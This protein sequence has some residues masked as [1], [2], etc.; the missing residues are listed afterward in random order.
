V[1]NKGG[2][3]TVGECAG[4]LRTYHTIFADF[5]ISFEVRVPRLSRQL[6]DGDFRPARATASPC[7]F[8]ALI[9]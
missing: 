3:V 6:A 2:I 9:R 1:R 7:P 8:G 5:T 4:W